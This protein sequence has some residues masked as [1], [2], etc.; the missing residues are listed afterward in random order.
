MWK[1]GQ[2]RQAR[3]A[4]GTSTKDRKGV[5]SRFATASCRFGLTSFT[6]PKSLPGVPDA[7]A[8]PEDKRRI[9]KVLMLVEIDVNGNPEAQSETN[10]QN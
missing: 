8:R 6:P 3:E 9:K 7:P 10:L 4:K 1:D 5:V 2:A